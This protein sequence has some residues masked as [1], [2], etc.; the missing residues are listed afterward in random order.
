MPDDDARLARLETTQEMQHKHLLERVLEA[1]HHILRIEEAMA[2]R[3]EENRQR[4]QELL[5]AVKDTINGR[6]RKV[7]GDQ[8]TL[9]RML[10]ELITARLEVQEAKNAIARLIV[11]GLAGGILIAFLNFI[12]GG[13]FGIHPTKVLPSAP[14][15]HS[16][17]EIKEK[18]AR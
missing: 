9:E 15:Y 8:T 14:P 12:V 7:E 5:A 6:I 10:R 3:H 17:E 13:W 16:T 2:R 4:H 18:P 1:E 11:F